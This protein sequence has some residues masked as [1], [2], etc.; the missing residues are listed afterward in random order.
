MCLRG[1]EEEKRVFFLFCHI[2][3]F[4]GY[5]WLINRKKG[6]QA[7]DCISPMMIFVWR[8]NEFN[9]YDLLK[10]ELEIRVRL[11]VIKILFFYYF[12]INTKFA[13]FSRGEQFGKKLIFM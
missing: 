1:D 9:F 6:K 4:Y 11:N 7:T 8:N 10:H 3:K 2:K 5:W 12:G 13:Y